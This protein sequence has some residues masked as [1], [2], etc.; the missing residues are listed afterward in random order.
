MTVRLLLVFLVLFVLPG[1][2][3]TRQA[4]HHNDLYNSRRSVS[5]LLAD[6]ETD[7]KLRAKLELVEGILQF[8]EKE[9]LNTQGAYHYLI[10]SG[11]NV[12]SYL[13]QA[14]EPDKL[15]SV[16]WWFPF[17]GNVP[18]LGY[19]KKKERDDKAAE[20]RAMGYDVH[21]GAAG[22]FSSLGW[23]DDPIFSSMLRRDE[24][25]L[26]HLFFHELTHRT[27]W[28]PASIKFN[29]N[30]AEYVGAELTVKYLRAK[31]EEDAI[32]KFE[33]KK[34]DRILFADWL[35]SV[36]TDLEKLYENPHK[37]SKAEIL[38]AKKALLD[39]YQRTPLR[40]L[41]KVIDYVEGEAWNNAAVLAASLYAPDT[42]A[43]EKAHACLRGQPVIVFLKTLQDLTDTVG[44]PF[45]ALDSVCRGGVARVDR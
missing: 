19:F 44:D 4:L 28:A 16:T 10:D 30:L 2:Y 8:A 25:D 12:V 41:F 32:K 45:V 42:Q 24:G 17:V 15:D 31:G 26:A 33:A 35:R 43:F 20:L 38:A 6:P 11:Q 22:A 3:A 23:F 37:K 40:P 29:E 13:V 18:Y 34:R 7:P 21:T 39:R 14:A 9:G 36:R 27:F 5:G 1:C